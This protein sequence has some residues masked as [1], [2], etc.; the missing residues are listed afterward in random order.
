[1]RKKQYDIEKQHAKGKMTTWERVAQLATVQV[2]LW[3][4]ATIVCGGLL[5]SIAASIRGRRRP[6]TVE[7]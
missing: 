3:V 2:C 6:G 7:P 4:P 5:G 1:M